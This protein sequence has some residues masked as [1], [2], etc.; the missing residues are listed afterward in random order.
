[1]K[2]KQVAFQFTG[3]LFLLTGLTYLGH[4]YLINKDDQVLQKLID[5]SYKF[6]VGITLLFTIT[7]F[8]LSQK[9]KDQLGF[10]FMVGSFIKIA[11]FLLWLKT[12]A[13]SVDKS[14]YMHFF[15]PY[16]LCLIVEIFYVSK[17][18]RNINFQ[19]DN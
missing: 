15:I 6:N 18:L 2:I 16:F 5:F 1:M 11:L 10:V 4:Q 7:I 17:I 19:N 8:L 12:S 3:V 13:I 9:L 14:T